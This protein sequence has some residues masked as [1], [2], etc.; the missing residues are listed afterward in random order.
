MRVISG[1]VEGL[2]DGYYGRVTHYR[3]RVFV[4]QLGFVDAV[5]G[6]GYLWRCVSRLVDE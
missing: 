5:H 4:E 6:E 2:P 1:A 3:H